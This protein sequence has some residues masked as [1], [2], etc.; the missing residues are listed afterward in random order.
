MVAVATVIPCST[1]HIKL[2]IAD[3]GDG[4]WDSAVFLKA[5]S[6][7]GGGNASIDWLVDGQTDV[8]EVTEGCGTVELLIDRVGSNPAL[9][10]TVS[11]T[12]TGTAING[13]DYGPIAGSYV[14]PAG[15]DQVTV[16]V[17][18][19]NDLVPEGAETVILTL[20]NP[21]SCLN[22]QEI[23][24][25][26]DYNPMEPVPDTVVIC[27]PGV[28]TVGVTVDGGVAPYTYQW[29]TSIHIKKQYGII[30]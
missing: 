28:A 8:D 12:I 2:K 5:G 19:V 10:L 11:F 22:P 30:H 29:A 24:T 6:F 4:A 15:Q 3:V 27:G 26:L 18:I 17:N 16:P 14:I 7:D 1:Y 25:I 13:V 23:L 9:P 21:C 20:N